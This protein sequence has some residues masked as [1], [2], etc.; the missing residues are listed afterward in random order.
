M[1]TPNPDPQP[2]ASDARAVVPPTT[3]AD[4]QRERAARIAA[5]AGRLAAEREARG[6]RSWSDLFRPPRVGAA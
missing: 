6:L 1:T 4:L 3:D 2:S 5:L